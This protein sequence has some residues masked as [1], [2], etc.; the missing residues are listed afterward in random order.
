MDSF[1]ELYF[2]CPDPLSRVHPLSTF[3]VLCGVWTLN[4]RREVMARKRFTAA[5]IIHKLHEAE[6]L[7]AQRR[8]TSE[9]CL[10]LG[11]RIRRNTA[12]EMST[13]G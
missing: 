2:D 6:V 11:S 13:A 3:I 1:F 5:E 4:R 7:L 9:V 8:K 10:K 12:C